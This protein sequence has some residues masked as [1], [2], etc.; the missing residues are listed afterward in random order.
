MLLRPLASDGSGP[1]AR[2]VEILGT[3]DCTCLKGRGIIR[4]MGG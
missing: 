4:L 3:L 1:L 2:R